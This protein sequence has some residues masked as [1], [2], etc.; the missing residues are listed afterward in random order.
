[1]VL[2]TV[3]KFGLDYDKLWIFD[4][5]HHEINQ[6]CS[7]H[8]LQEVFVDLFDTLDESLATALATDLQTWAP[9]IQIIATRVTKPKIPDSLRHDYIRMEE[10]KTKLL[11]SIESQK[12]IE[13]KAE[14]EHL[15]S[16]IEAEMESEVNAIKMKQKLLEKRTYET[17]ERLEDEINIAREKALTD[18][19]FYRSTKLSDA[20]QLKL[21]ETYIQHETYQ[22]LKETKKVYMGEDLPSYITSA[23]EGDY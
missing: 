23:V 17:L 1:M 5:I 13:K 20:N 12:V 14:T 11:I 2:E 22:R 7:S 9:G 15:K 6:F 21:T 3:R 10:E 4:K 16:I 18:A 19:K 8:S